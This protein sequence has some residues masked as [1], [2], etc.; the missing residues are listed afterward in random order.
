VFELIE[1][2]VA[3]SDACREK[4]KGVSGYSLSREGL[5]LNAVLGH[6]PAF[7]VNGW[8]QIDLGAIGVRLTLA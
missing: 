1:R 2:G 5:R 8:Q 3:S 6:R 4:P 7:W